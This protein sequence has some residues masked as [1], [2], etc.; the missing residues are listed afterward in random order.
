M[1][2]K[3]LSE[4]A[5]HSPH[6]YYTLLNGIIR[7][8]HRIWLGHSVQLQQRVLSALHASAMG[9]HSG[10]EVT[11]NRVKRFFAWP[12]MKNSV[13]DFVAT[14][15]ICQQVKTERVAYPGLL[16]P[17]PIPEGAWQVVT[18]DFIKGLPKSNHYNSILVVVDKFSR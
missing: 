2:S 14:C 6:D 11:Y 1:A 13:K 7:Y 10:Y 17:L 8:K 4:L 15:A 5:L 16:S 18:L 9:G 3:L 12:K